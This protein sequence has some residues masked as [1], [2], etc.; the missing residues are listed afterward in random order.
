MTASKNNKPLAEM[1]L[2]LRHTQFYGKR[3]EDILLDRRLVKE[4]RQFQNVIITN[5]L[6]SSTWY[7]RCS[8]IDAIAKTINPNRPLP[9]YD[10][11]HT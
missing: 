11:P 8:V 2:E 5:L 3:S 7:I 10:T 6:D 9:C 4:S 1:V